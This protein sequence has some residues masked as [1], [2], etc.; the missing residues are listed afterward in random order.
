MSAPEPILAR[1]LFAQPGHVVEMDGRW[2]WNGQEWL[3]LQPGDECRHAATGAS[4]TWTGESWQAARW[5]KSDRDELAAVLDPE[6]FSG[7]D[8]EDAAHWDTRRALARESARRALAHGYVLS[9]RLAALKPVVHHLTNLAYEVGDR[10]DVTWSNGQRTRHQVSAV[11]DG[12]PV[13]MAL[14]S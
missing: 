2:R 14:E 9:T 13:L 1:S 12:H 4:V 11:V 6:A 5:S 8:T 10:V 7:Q 3:P